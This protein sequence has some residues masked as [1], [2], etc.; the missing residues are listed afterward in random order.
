MEI[1]SSLDNFLSRLDGVKKT[2]KSWQAR[3]PAHEDRTPS[4]SIKVED[5]KILI[6]C[7]AGCTTAD[8]VSAIG[9]KVSDL[10]EDD[11]SA[12]NSFEGGNGR[13]QSEES[14]QQAAARAARIWGS[15]KPCPADHGYLAKKGIKPYTARVHKGAL[16]LPLTDFSG[17]I[18]SLQFIDS[19]GGK[20]NM[21]GGR[22]KGSFIHVN[23]DLRDPGRVIICEGWATGCTLEEDE[24]ESLVLAAIDANN[25][26]LVAVS[27]REHWQSTELIIAGDDDRQKHK[28]IGRI[29]ATE[30]AIRSQAL[31]ALPDWP[32]HAP[33]DLV[34][35]NDLAQWRAGG[36]A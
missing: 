8:I 19:K 29:K 10:F 20:K 24:P 4:L 36:A 28:N 26:V 13:H 14:E 5:G 23:G 11:T 9:L 21:K 18:T 6:H 31:L 27:A 2:P 16:V 12:S 30:A 32:D 25:L 17:K 15:A 1:T 3:C 33:E 7:F 34:D 22:K 35:F